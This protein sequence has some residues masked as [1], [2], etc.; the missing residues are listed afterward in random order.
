M[1]G[2]FG[3]LFTADEY[4]PNLQ[5]L[6][7]A[8]GQQGSAPGVET[9][10]SGAPGSSALASQPEGEPGPDYRSTRGGTV[11]NRGNGPRS[12]APTSNYTGPRHLP[13][14]QTVTGNNNAHP[15]NPN[16]ESSHQTLAQNCVCWDI[17]RK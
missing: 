16:S 12:P 17:L 2:F 10:A 9:S 6:Y 8:F 3:S 14:G 7:S 13:G 5:D 4:T 1:S 15:R 11:S